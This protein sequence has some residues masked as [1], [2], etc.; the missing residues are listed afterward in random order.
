MCVS[1]K[2]YCHKSV[3][4]SVE[5]SPW[6]MLASA[7]WKPHV[8]AS[9]LCMYF[10]HS[11]YRPAAVWTPWLWQDAC[12]GCCCGSNR[13]TPHLSQGAQLQ[14]HSSGTAHANFTTTSSATSWTCPS[15]HIPAVSGPPAQ[16]LFEGSDAVSSLMR[17]LGIAY[18]YMWCSA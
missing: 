11:C 14:T 8:V 2:L 16:L 7:E 6:P 9:D 5:L 15:S 4:P 13:C 10:L 3:Q 17:C 1:L 12:G 18:T